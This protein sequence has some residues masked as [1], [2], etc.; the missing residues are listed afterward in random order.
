MDILEIQDRKKCIT[1]IM[2]VWSEFTALIND[3]DGKK[4]NND[5]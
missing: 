2:D 3:L 1:I 5:G 4:E